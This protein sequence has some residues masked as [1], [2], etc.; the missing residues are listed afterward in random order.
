MGIPVRSDPDQS[1][2]LLKD[3]A[4]HSPATRDNFPQYPE[5]IGTTSAPRW[6]KSPR[7]PVNTPTSFHPLRAYRTDSALDS[8]P[9][10]VHVFPEAQP[11][12]SQ[13]IASV[14][15]LARRT[16]R[17]HLMRF[18][19]RA[20]PHPLRRKTC[21]DRKSRLCLHGRQQRSR[22]LRRCRPRRPACMVR[23]LRHLRP[24]R[25]RPLCLLHPLPPRLHLQVRHRHRHPAA[26]RTRQARPRRSCPK[27]L[28]RLPAKRFAHHLAP[29]PPPPRPHSPL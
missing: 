26:L 9:E 2:G 27:I 19:Y 23:W 14:F 29:T 25:L 21:P 3:N 11:F 24:R 12:A 17:S 1:L 8:R 5:W 15:L 28:P 13:V 10:V 22:R 7:P 4:K 6:Y 20:R 16:A 18:R